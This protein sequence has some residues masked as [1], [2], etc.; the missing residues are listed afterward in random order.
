M[1]LRYLCAAALALLSTHAPAARAAT[2]AQRVDAIVRA[3]G[4]TGPQTGIAILDGT[5]NQFIY[6]R[7]QTAELKAASN[8]KLTTTAAA[9]A[10]IG[11]GARLHTDVYST[12]TRSGT[13]LR[14]S[15]WLVGG[16]DPSLSSSPFTYKAFGGVSGRIGDLAAAVRAAGILRVTGHV[17]GDE[18][19]FDR[20]RV[21]PLWKASY[22]ID[23]PPLTALSV[24]EDLVRFGH[25]NAYANPPLRSAQVLI[26]A[27]RARGVRVD[28]SPGVATRP[29]T[30]RLVATEAS[31]P[32]YRLVQQMNLPSDNFFAEVL[33]KDIAVHEGLRGTTHNGRVV[34]RAYL[35]SL[36][37]DLTG[38]RFYDGSGLSLGDR[39]SARQILAV[40]RQASL[41][42]YGWFFRNSLPLAGV[43]GTLSK[44]MRSGPAYRNA[45]AKTGT[46][47]DASAL[48]G[49]VTSAN[50]HQIVFSIVVNHDPLL[51]ITAAR[52][53]QDRIVQTLAGSRPA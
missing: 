5:R 31:P 51:N 7:N 48:S 17:Y 13:T 50:G 46:L 30:A 26:G 40:L 10:K 53:L 45:R 43:S 36:G 8:T 1:K 24:N 19:A 27:L 14:G 9:L 32:I 34:T 12:G 37:I 6:L 42:N 16:G 41:R 44:R 20:V 4:F 25:P 11:I 18:S 33:N 47:Q 21:G 22:R 35:A 23:C 39:L 29:G 38:A 15:L 52:A 28:G 49:Y 3:S 2:L